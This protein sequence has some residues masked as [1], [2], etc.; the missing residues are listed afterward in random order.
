MRAGWCCT[1]AACISTTK[2]DDDDGGFQPGRIDGAAAHAGQ[3]RKSGEPYITH[4]LAV[5]LI[6]A[7]YGLDAMPKPLRK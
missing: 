2:G 7:G 4:P 6:L 5:A 3:V 1:T